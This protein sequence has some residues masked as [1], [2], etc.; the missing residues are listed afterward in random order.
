MNRSQDWGIETALR[1]LES[2][3]QLKAYSFSLAE[4]THKRIDE[5][6]EKG[7]SGHERAE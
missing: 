6:L 5:F 4:E 2:G 1:V 3:R 7:F